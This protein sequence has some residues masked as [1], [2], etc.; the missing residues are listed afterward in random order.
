LLSLLNKLYP[1]HRTISS[2]DT[3]KAYEIVQ[4]E[5]PK[6]FNPT[7]LDYEPDSKVW[8]WKVPKKY[9]VKK[10]ILKDEDGNIYAD[11]NENPLY[12]WSY[13]IS[14]N[15]TLSFDELESHLYYSKICPDSTAWRFK[16]YDK[17]WGFCIPYNVYKTMPRDKKYIVEI[18]SEFLDESF[19]LM[20]SFVDYGCENEFVICTNIC[21][22]YQVNDSISGLVVAVELQKRLAKKPIEKPTHNINFLYCPETIGSITYLANNDDKIEKTTGGIFVEM[23]GHKDDDNFIL[24][25]SLQTDSLTDVIFEYILKK[26]NKSFDLRNFQRWNDEGIFNSFGIDIPMVFL[27][28]GKC[29]YLDKNGYRCKTDFY[30][31]YHTSDDNPSII[32]EEKLIETANIIEEAIRIYCTNYIPIQKEKGI[33]FF[34]GIGMHTAIEENRKVSLNLEKLSYMLNGEYSVFDIALKLDI[35]YWEIKEFIDEL[36][37]KGVIDGY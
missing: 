22:P 31:E 26:Y 19:K 14:I 5:I 10:A 15:K 7:I 36:L 4:K 1:L 32:S 18:D 37:V 30:K 24:Q 29:K 3:D 8:Y 28:K 27:M 17:T 20:D 2:Y 34:S 9:N 23:V 12:I 33:I 16:Y 21:H 35:D 13:S 25:K 6:E 11:F